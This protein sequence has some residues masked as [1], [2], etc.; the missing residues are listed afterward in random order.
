[1]SL[2]GSYGTLG[3]GVASVAGGSV[4][5]GGFCVGASVAG[6]CVGGLVGGGFV[7]VAR[8]VELGF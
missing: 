6:G 3:G 2:L 4:G 5:S 7:S 8:G 1:V